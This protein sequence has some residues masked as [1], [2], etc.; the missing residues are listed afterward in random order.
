MMSTL[1]HASVGW[2]P[3]KIGFLFLFITNLA[4]A[5]PKQILP[6]QQWT[7]SEGSR[8]YFVPAPE[9]PMVDIQVA[10][11]AGSARDPK[12]QDG[13]ALF[14]NQLLTEGTSD[15]NAD[16]IASGFE[17][18]GAILNKSLDRDMAK[19]HL[20]TITA[21]LTPALGLFTKIL[22]DSTFPKTSFDREK[23]RHLT[24]IQ[25]QAQN[26]GTI[27]S[28]AIY[29]AIYNEH[30]YAHEPL[31]T[32]KTVTVLTPEQVKRF[33]KTYY[34]A[35]NAVIG[36]V[37]AVDRKQAESIANEISSKLNR[38]KA[39][40]TLPT[41]DV[42]RVVAGEKKIAHPSTQTHIRMGTVGIAVNDPDYFPLILGNNILGGK[43][44]VSR[45]F[46][47]V[48]E[49]RG[50]SYHAASMFMPLAMRGP[51][52]VILQTET[53]QA[54]LALK[55]A[56]ETVDTFIAS[57]PTAKELA[58]AKT[59]IAGGLMLS[60]NSNDAIVD[61]IT[62]AGFYNLPLDY[63]DTYVSNMNNVTAEQM[64]DAFQRRISTKMA[65]VLVGKDAKPVAQ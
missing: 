18:I 1:R 59:D 10:F 21:Q 9:I 53:Q 49:K 27:A 54:P 58:G 24:A 40:A 42:A 43:M 35:E 46:K 62:K 65:T 11:A 36:I 39:A 63:L 26:P 19:V 20:R 50:L 2:H 56:Q 60:I 57:G 6:I 3:V 22:S 7:T 51:F 45:L 38:G 30:P 12:Q 4:F 13:L 47:E 44:I 28:N 29:R 8:V 17:S 52:I 33:F 14:T 32:Q 61:H 15:L 37:G 41:V 31:G 16:Q 25:A 5:A 48:R 55:T 64:K 34:V 23:N